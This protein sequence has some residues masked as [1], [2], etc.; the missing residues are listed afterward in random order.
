VPVVV[1][2]PARF[3]NQAL[4]WLPKTPTPIRTTMAIVA[5]RSP[6]STT[7]WPDSS[8]RKR[9]TCRNLV[10][11]AI[12]DDYVPVVVMRPARFRNH[13]LILLPKKPTPMRTTIA[14][15]AISK[16]YSTTS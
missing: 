3:W 2:R 12:A 1:I 6:Y 4:I 7:S 10:L 11:L 8:E 14:M 16:P 9:K 13:A 5:M 15:V